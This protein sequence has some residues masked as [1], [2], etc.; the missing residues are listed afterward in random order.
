MKHSLSNQTRSP[1][2]SMPSNTFTTLRS[3]P[4]SSFCFRHLVAALT[5]CL[6]FVSTC[7]LADFEK[8]KI[9]YRNND[10]KT[11][12]I[13]FRASADEGDASSQWALGFLHTNG[14]GLPKDSR[15]AAE[16]YRK[17]ADQGH[18]G[19]QNNLGV[20]YDNG[21][22]VPKDSRLAAEWYPK[23]PTKGKLALKTTLVSVTWRAHACPRIC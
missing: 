10:F 8:G 3:A 17:A 7:A 14:E 23:P 1:A 2:P 22:G 6:C 19:A 16:W 12:L 13:E 21:E 5:S 20:S 15:L 18:A 4:S 9:A 11:A